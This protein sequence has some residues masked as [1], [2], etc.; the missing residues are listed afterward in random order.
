MLKRKEER[1]IKSLIK[2]ELCSTNS[3]I[4]TDKYRYYVTSIY[5]AYLK[6]DS[7]PWIEIALK[8]V[9]HEW[10]IKSRD[11]IPKLQKELLMKR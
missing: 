1:I 11:F 5:A 8:E 7:N 2:D 10:E 9:A 4:V 6:T 3:F